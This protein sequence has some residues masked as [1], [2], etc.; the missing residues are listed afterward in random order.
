[1][2]K[3]QFLAYLTAALLLTQSATYGRAV[4]AD[5]TV[6]NTDISDDAS[7]TDASAEDTWEPRT[8][9]EVF[10]KMRIAAEN[11]NLAFWVWDTEALADGEHQED[12]FA[13]VNKKN[14][15]VWWSSPINAGGDKIATPVL[16][17]ELQSALVLTSAE[18][19]ARST[20]N[21]RS[22]D[23]SK[24]KII[25]KNV[26]NGITVT[27]N[28]NKIGIKIPVTYTLC[29][30]YLNVQIDSSEIT[31]KYGE[32]TE[33]EE[34]YIIAQSLAVLN[35]F[36]AADSTETGSFIIPDG[37]GAAI[38][39]NNKKYTA[40]TY[41]QLVYGAD[42]TAVPKVKGATVEGISLP[43]YGICK[44]ENAML[45]VAADGDGS[46]KLCA[47]VS[48]KGQS[49]TE[50][51]RCYFQFILRSEDSYYLGSDT[52]NPL[53]IYEKSMKPLDINVRYYP[54]CAADECNEDDSESLDCVDIAARYRKYLLD[55]CGVKKS[56]EQA[57]AKL[58]ANIYCGCEKQKNILGFPIYM[59]TSMTSYQEAQE[60]LQN[61][62]NAGAEHLVATLH[63]WTNAGISG[64]VDYK[65]KPAGVLGGKSDFRKLTAYLNAQ[66]IAWY[67]VVNN[68]AY[69]SGCGYFAL[70]DT[71]VRV[72]GA[73]ARIV[74]YEP[75]FGVPY[76]KKDNRSLLTPNAFPELY[77]KLAKNYKAAGI[78]SVSIGEL[79]SM[80]YGDYG[81]KS[82]ASREVAKDYIAE[83]TKMLQS[84]L[85]SI[86]SQHPNAYVLPYSDMLTDMPL[87][88]SS[89]TIFD[90]EIPLYQLIMHGVTP[91]ATK[92]VNG[93][94]DA[95]QLVLLAAATGSNLS[96]DLL[97]TDPS[98]YRDTDFDRFYYGLADYWV[99]PAAQYY[100]FLSP[101]TEAAGNAEI[102]SYSRSGDIIT[103]TYENGIQTVT[104]LQNKTVTL[105]DQ[106]YRLADF[107]EKGDAAS[108]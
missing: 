13:L 107:T 25:M 42:T 70:T 84:E 11:D 62:Q 58:V 47:D 4:Y 19:N 82:A 22:G 87:S 18:P 12:V 77:K 31:E 37:A 63:N 17:K 15:Y 33:D 53:T 1:M 26:P 24:C 66:Q 35:A 39:F 78:S 56:T 50:Y 83:S 65:A 74:D 75:A 45:A 85:G 89:F 86:L 76:G 73:F 2:M 98:V 36:G 28:F 91:Y 9:S 21:A 16:C 34:K 67:P 49:N 10:K 64:K 14:G 95:E 59:K 96:V 7:I 101:I 79:A 71:A 100:R 104:N 68:S 94:A 90:E 105:N 38:H 51:N 61:L 97:H 88:S 41:S 44:G 103:T 106:T 6:A 48:G 72:S 57:S 52:Q 99:K 46:C 3:K 20:S 23:F 102:I 92:A 40:K 54:L 108:E 55:E 32:N 8:E 93:S 30:D 60:I 80:L 69:A 5:E 43:M 27:Y 81:K 29:E